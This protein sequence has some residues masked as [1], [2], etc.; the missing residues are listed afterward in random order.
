MTIT[1]E[2]VASYL[3]KQPDCHFSNTFDGNMK[4]QKLLVFANLIHFTEYNEFLFPEEMFAFKNGIVVEDVRIPFHHD[5]FNYMNKLRE[6]SD[7]ELGND[8]KNSIDMSISLFNKLS[9]KELSDLH[10]EMETWKIKYHKSRIG[11]FYDKN[12]SLIRND[13]VLESDLAKLRKVI[14]G[15]KRNE[16]EQFACEKVNGITFYF[17]PSEIELSLSN[18]SFMDYLEDLSRSVVLGE[19]DTFYLAYDEDQGIYYY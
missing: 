1:V 18:E 13:E 8:Q 2:K 7:F 4:L 17:D 11:S 5:Y 16:K 3:A 6:H 10:H 12:I 14:Q 19:D 9:A 15:F